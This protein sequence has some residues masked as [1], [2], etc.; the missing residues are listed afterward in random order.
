[1]FNNQNVD[2]GKFVLRLSISAQANK[3][4]FGITNKRGIQ[5]GIGGRVG[6]KFKN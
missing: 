1:M 4:I 3:K 6:K 2:I 5:I